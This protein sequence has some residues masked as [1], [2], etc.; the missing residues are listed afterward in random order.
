MESED[1]QQKISETSPSVQTHLAILQAVIER[2][3]GNSNS[4]KTWCITIVSSI[5]VVVAEE[6]KPDYALLALLPT[7][8]FISL[9]AYYLGLEKAFRNSYNSFVKKLHHSKITAEDLFSVSPVGSVTKL[10]FAASKSF[11]IWGFYLFLIAL[12]ILSR[13]FVLK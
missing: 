3:A 7:F 10:Q 11:S 4:C 12:I 6:S 1:E 9:D 2:M 5:L 13:V 8:L